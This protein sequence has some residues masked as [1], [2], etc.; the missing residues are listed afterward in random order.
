LAFVVSVAIVLLRLAWLRRLHFAD[1]VWAGL[2]VLFAYF[3]LRSWW[4]FS[5][6]VVWLVPLGAILARRP[7]ATF[8]VLFAGAAM[9]M[10]ALFGWRSLLF[11]DAPQAPGMFNLAVSFVI[12]GPAL[13]YLCYRGLVMLRSRTGRRERTGQEPAPYE[14]GPEA[15]VPVSA[16]QDLPIGERD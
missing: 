8:M 5:W 4:F 6:Y 7:S 12:F 1:C 2:A 16:G 9:A 10:N 15:R 11:G 13:L 3:A 14:T